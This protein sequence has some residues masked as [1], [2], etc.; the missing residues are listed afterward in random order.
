MAK[1]TVER[2]LKIV[3]SL[4]VFV[5]MDQWESPGKVDGLDV[6]QILRTFL[7]IAELMIC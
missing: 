7:D 2:V 5:D 6:A 3:E 1:E 4:S